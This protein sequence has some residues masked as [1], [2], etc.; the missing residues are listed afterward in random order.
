MFESFDICLFEVLF[1]LNN[2][3]KQYS[4][5]AVNKFN[6]KIIKIY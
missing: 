2:N 5:E 3:L 4:F 1:N 6:N